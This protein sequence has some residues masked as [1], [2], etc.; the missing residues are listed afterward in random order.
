MKK[1]FVVFLLVF[2]IISCKK[3]HN[4]NTD[5]STLNT[6]ISLTAENDTISLGES[7]K[8][9]AVIDGNNVSF[10]WSATAGDILGSGNEITYVAPPCTPGNNEITCT[11]SASNNSETKKIT[12]VVL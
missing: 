7:T 4:D 1:I 2:F 9:A 3:D 8:I 11:A 12:I 10:S 5:D 6:F